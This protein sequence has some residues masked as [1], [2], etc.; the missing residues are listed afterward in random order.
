[1]LIR[2]RIAGPDGRPA[3][4]VFVSVARSASAGEVMR[5]D[6]SQTVSVACTPEDGGERV[7]SFIRRSHDTPT[8]FGCAKTDGR[9]ELQVKEPGRYTVLVQPARLLLRQL[10]VVAP[11]E[12]LRIDLK[13][14]VTVAGRVLDSTGL[15]S[16]GARL[17]LE[18]PG[19]GIGR[20]DARFWIREKNAISDK[21]GS[22]EFEGVASGLHV[23]CADLSS[24]DAAKTRRRPVAVC[25]PLDV[26][27]ASPFVT[28]RAPVAYDLRS[29]GW[30][31]GMGDFN[32]PG[33]GPERDPVLQAG[34]Q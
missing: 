19:K 17:T 26:K 32:L 10:E 31:S 34:D 3:T 4:D 14:G 8:V 13:A 16:A 27:G 23:V 24:A 11:A 25:T 7:A 22:F 18:V 5:E 30:T 28:L 12:N 1:V 6:G 9:F 15:P 20:H 21:D 2:G 33:G 29:S